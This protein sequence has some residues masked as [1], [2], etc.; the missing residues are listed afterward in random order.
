LIDEMQDSET[1][2]FPAQASLLLPL[3]QANSDAARTAFLPLYAGQAA[4]LVRDLPAGHSSKRSW[5]RQRSG[6][7][8]ARACRQMSQIVVAAR[9]IAARK[10]LAVLS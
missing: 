8:A 3:R 10:F 2:E 1:L 9:W 7:R 6:Y 4:P 5:P